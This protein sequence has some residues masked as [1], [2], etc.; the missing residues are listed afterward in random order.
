MPKDRAHGLAILL[1]VLLGIAPWR[2]GADAP[3][4]HFFLSKIGQVTTGIGPK[5][6]LFLPGGRRLV[7]A[8]LYGPG[9]DVLTLEPFSHE[10][11]ITLDSEVFGFVETV[12]CA[13]RREIWV[14]QMF[15][16]SMRVLDA[17]SFELLRT[18][19]SGGSW[20]K[21]ITLSP[22]GTLAIASNWQSK[23]VTF[24]DTD[25]GSVYATIP[26]RG[27]PRGV[28]ASA[29]GT[30]LYVAN[31]EDGSITVIDIHTSRVRSTIECGPGAKRH[32]VIDTQRRLLYA[33]DMYTGRI[34]VVDLKD[35]T[36]RISDRFGSNPNTIALS[37]D[38]THLFVSY[39]GKN[40]PTDYT[41]PGP[42]PGKII[43]LETESLSLCAT[44]Q[45]GYQPTGLALSP[46]GS[47][48]A[49]SNFLDNTVELYASGLGT[50]TGDTTATSVD[51][52]GR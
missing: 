43:V 45:G 3:E 44:V 21:A 1:C 46:D 2:I 30:E 47:L 26:I 28:A 35:H 10:R 38:G 52:G 49:F 20:P 8:L 32:L 14:S 17:T 27:T 37:P 48:L 13:D 5:S 19:P 51:Q 33:S 12:Y 16:D 22:D 42:E 25:S 23:T 29:D 24:I 9:V 50:P 4:P 39:R 18:I 15:T 40:H 36:Y 6:V 34:T 11:R 41:L 31:F 7:V